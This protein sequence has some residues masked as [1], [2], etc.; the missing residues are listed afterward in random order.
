MMG[1]SFDIV[2]LGL[3]AVDDLVS[4]ERYPPPDSKVPI[5][6]RVRRCGGL[7]ATALVA[8]ARLGS[9]VAYAGIVGNDEDSRFV[10]DALRDKGVDTDHVY[11]YPGARPVLSTV[12]IDEAERTRTIFMDT[13]GLV[14]PDED[15]LPRELLAT[16]RV[17]LVDNFRIGLQIRAAR[18]ARE[19]GAAVVADLD[20]ALSPRLGE[21]IGLADHLI[22]SSSYAT[23]LTGEHDPRAAALALRAPGRAVVITRGAEG[24]WYLHDVSSEP[25]HQE[26]FPVDAVDTNGCGDVFHGAYAVALADRL[27]LPLRVRSASATA[28]LSATTPGGQEGIPDAD[29]VTH[30]LAGHDGPPR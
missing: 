23:L 22:V 29:A 24:S 15:W 9:R 17:L 12:V 18:F 5:L 30:F 1:G 26:A 16:C 19:S 4:V 14:G 27:P 20:G 6:R 7:N 2:G 8:A 25:A 13:S 11:V 10:L 28:A 3:A 21:L